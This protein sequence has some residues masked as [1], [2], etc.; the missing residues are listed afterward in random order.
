MMGEIRYNSDRAHNIFVSFCYCFYSPMSIYMIR[1]TYFIY[2]VLKAESNHYKCWT[3][4]A[5]TANK[6]P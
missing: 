4:T 3:L 2:L 1:N 6:L 5:T